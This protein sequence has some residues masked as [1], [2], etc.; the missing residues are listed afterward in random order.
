MI[1]GSNGGEMGQR[2]AT[3]LDGVQR[4]FTVAAGRSGLSDVE[5]RKA[6]WHLQEAG[7]YV[8]ADDDVAELLI[9]ALNATQAFLMTRCWNKNIGA[10]SK[11]VDQELLTV[12]LE[13]CANL[14]A[15]LERLPADAVSKALLIES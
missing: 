7:N 6:C 15:K 14:R 8:E 5:V 11:P 3:T 12:A 13:T 4:Y 1:L 10:L 9:A 2:A